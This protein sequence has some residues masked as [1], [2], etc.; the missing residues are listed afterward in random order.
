MQSAFFIS[1]IFAAV[2]FTFL[3]SYQLMHRLDSIYVPVIF[4]LVLFSVGYLAYS[5]INAIAIVPLCIG[6]ASLTLSR[7][8]GFI[9]AIVVAVLVTFLAYSAELFG[10]KPSIMHRAYIFGTFVPIFLSS[11]AS[12]YFIVNHRTKIPVESNAGT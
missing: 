11:I 10:H 8:A 1:P 4:E 2:V 7:M 5:V 9:L 12:F 6:F 3:E